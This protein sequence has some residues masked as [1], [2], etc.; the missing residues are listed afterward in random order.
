MA[1]RNEWDELQYHNKEN[2]DDNVENWDRKLNDTNANDD[3]EDNATAHFTACVALHNWACARSLVLCTFHHT[4]KGSSS[5]LARTPLT[6][7]HMSSMCATSSPWTPLST[8]QPSSCLSSFSPSSTSA[9]SSS[10]SSTRRSWKTRATPPTTG[11]RAPTTSSTSPQNQTNK[12]VFIRALGAESNL[13]FLAVFNPD[14]TVKILCREVL[15]QNL[16]RRTCCWGDFGTLFLVQVVV[17]RLLEIFN[18]LA[19]DGECKQVHLSRAMFER[20]QLFTVCL[21]SYAHCT[22]I[23]TLHAWLKIALHSKR[24]VPSLAPCLTPWHT[25]HEARLPHHFLLFLVLFH[26]EGWVDHIHNTLRRS[27]E[28]TRG[29]QLSWTT[30]SHRLWAQQDRRQPDHWWIGE[31]DLHRRRSDY[32]NEDHVKALSHNQSFLSSTQ[33]S[34]ESIATPQEADFDDEQIPA[35]LA[36]PRYL[37]EEEWSAERSQVYQKAWCP[38]HL[39]VWNLLAQGTCSIVFTSEQVESRR[40]FREREQLADVLV[41]NKSI[42]RFSNPANVAKSFSWWK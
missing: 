13:G 20:V 8:S 22:W 14:W 38:F 41:S 17:F 29:R 21:H 16:H 28:T 23:H 11:V 39:K 32:W 1:T 5:S 42:F 15:Q 18:S 3:G 26:R 35:L 27:T 33:D 10:R 7:I 4:H 12:F 31:R 19:T 40:I 30:S 24:V 37:P 9:T 36:S 6:V 34:A 2:R 25:V